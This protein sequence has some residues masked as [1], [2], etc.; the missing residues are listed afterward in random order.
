LP[1]AALI[2][3]A[4]LV[5]ITEMYIPALLVQDAA[6]PA[7]FFVAVL[8]I[9]QLVFFSS[10]GPMI[11]DMFRDIPVRGRELVVLF[12]MRTVLLIPVLAL[13]TALLT[14]AG[15]LTG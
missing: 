2:A 11:I 4:V 8:S 7:R 5:G 10:V 14:G 15:L 12:L 1:D 6:A 9:S 13:I 3:P